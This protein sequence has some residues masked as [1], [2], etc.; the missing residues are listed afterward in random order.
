LELPSLL[1]AGRMTVLESSEWL[2]PTADDAVEKVK[3]ERR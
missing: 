2:V 3:L 1:A